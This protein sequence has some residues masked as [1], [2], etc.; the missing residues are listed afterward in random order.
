MENILKSQK[1]QGKSDLGLNKGPGE[2]KGVGDGN[3]NGVKKDPMLTEKTSPEDL[4]LKWK[5][6]KCRICGLL[7]E[8]KNVKVPCP[9]CGNDDPDMFDEL[10]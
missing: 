3:D 5:R 8:G 2:V 1:Q 4:D 6:I 9:K 7:Q 10:D